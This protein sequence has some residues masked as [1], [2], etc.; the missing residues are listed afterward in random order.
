MLMV[1]D[2]ILVRLLDFFHG[3]SPGGSWR[4]SMTSQL[5]SL[6]KGILSNPVELKF[7]RTFEIF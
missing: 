2:W 6:E 3:D 4:G 7:D 1:D 5:R